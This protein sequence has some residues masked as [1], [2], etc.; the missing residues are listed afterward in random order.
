[1]NLYCMDDLGLPQ[2]H[3]EE[4]NT[5]GHLDCDYNCYI[6]KDKEHW[7]KRITFSF[8]TVSQRQ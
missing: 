6:Y 4:L 1:M 8:K 7:R 3:H 5:L 2:Q